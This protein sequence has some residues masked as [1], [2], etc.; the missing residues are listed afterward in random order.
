[1]QLYHSKRLGLSE[2]IAKL[3]VAPAR[4]LRLPKG[5]LTIGADADIT[6]FD[7]ER[8]WRF[9]NR[10]RASKSLNSPFDGWP[11]KGKPVA[12]IVRGRK[13][14]VEQAEVAEA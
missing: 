2:L 10:G 14:W 6:V 12:A 7:P 1:M 4:L 5:T 11:L 9:D 8:E 13:A 3:T